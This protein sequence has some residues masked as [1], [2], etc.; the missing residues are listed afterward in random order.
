MELLEKTQKHYH[1]KGNH[2]NILTDN[3]CDNANA[4]EEFHKLKLDLL[5]KQ[6]EH[7]Q[8]N[9]FNYETFIKFNFH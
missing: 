4:S 9:T 5:V 7:L 1:L 8:V 6:M 3:D 2:D